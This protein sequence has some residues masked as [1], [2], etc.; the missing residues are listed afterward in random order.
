MTGYRETA[1]AATH[2]A[3]ALASA[4]PQSALNVL[5]WVAV[6]ALFAPNNLSFLFW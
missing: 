5:L 3:S 4:N 1:T 6:N 2:T